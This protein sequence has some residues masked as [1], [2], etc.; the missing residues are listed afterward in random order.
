MSLAECKGSDEVS[1]QLSCVRSLIGFQCSAKDYGFI[2]TL[3]RGFG[4]HPGNGH[5]QPK[6]FRSFHRLVDAI[7]SAAAHLL[8]CLVVK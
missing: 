7:S 8:P 3:R 2:C 5:Q 4:D 1:E 6:R